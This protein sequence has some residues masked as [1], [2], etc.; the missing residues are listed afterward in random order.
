MKKTLLLAVAA[1]MSMAAM[2][3][4]TFSREMPCKNNL[5][6]VI[7]TKMGTICLP[8][9]ATP[10]DCKTYKL[11]SASAD[12]WVFQEVLKMDANTPYVFVVENNTTLEANFK[13]EGEAVACEAPVAEAAGVAGA[14]VGSYK[15]K[16]IRNKKMYFLS[17][18][19]VNYNDG[20]PIVATPYRAYF[21]ASVMPAGQ[22]LSENVKLTFLQATT[23][24]ISQV[25]DEDAAEVTV[26]RQN[27]G[28]QQGKYNI[29]GKK[30]VVK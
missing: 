19:K 28:L 3:Q 10:V 16:V 20:L 30:V 14:F 26:A 15:E 29:N 6:Q 5:G 13:Q 22:K 11:V 7:A 21:D 1:L 2:A 17:Y 18:D 27:I 12:E 4:E 9:A 8:Y 24:R 23:T 25:A